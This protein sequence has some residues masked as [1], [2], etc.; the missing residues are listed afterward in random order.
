L[1][2]GLQYYT[3]ACNPENPIADLVDELRKGDVE[4]DPYP[5][6]N[7][8]A[9][10]FLLGELTGDHFDA[11]DRV[12]ERAA[13][14][15]RQKG[16]YWRKSAAV[17]AALVRELVQ[18]GFRKR[19][20]Q[21]EFAGRYWAAFSFGSRRQRGSTISQIGFLRDMAP[22]D[23]EITNGLTA[24]LASLEGAAPFSLDGKEG[25]GQG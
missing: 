25:D 16:G 9:L 20:V 24:L 12:E 8:L 23:S 6:V 7:V 5:A 22:K 2:A 14:S 18:S 19:E 13:Q 17:D 3:E 21:D 15:A 10:K 11:I 1:Q 4:F